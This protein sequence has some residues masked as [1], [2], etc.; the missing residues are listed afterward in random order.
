MVH[1]QITPTSIAPAKVVHPGTVGVAQIINAQVVSNSTSIS[2][3]T[4]MLIER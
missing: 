3:M 4:T 2:G 1:S